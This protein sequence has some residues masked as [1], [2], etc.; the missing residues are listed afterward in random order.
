MNWPSASIYRLHAAAHQGNSVSTSTARRSPVS[1]C[2]IRPR[3][4][5]RCAASEEL[6]AH[7]T[8]IA[9]VRSASKS[10]RS[11]AFALRNRKLVRCAVGSPTIGQDITCECA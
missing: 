10:G 4:I 3:Q 9:A 2:R 7:T 1:G 11:D 8:R 6:L 5:L